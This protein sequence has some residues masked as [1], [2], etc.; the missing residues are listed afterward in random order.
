MIRGHM[1][2]AVGRRRGDEREPHPLPLCVCPFSR[3]SRVRLLSSP[4]TVAHQ[5]SL[6]MQFS[7]Q[8]CWSG[9]PFP[10]PGDLPDPGIEPMSPASPSLQANSLP[11]SHRGSPQYFQM[12]PIFH[13]FHFLRFCRK[14]PFTPVLYLLL[15]GKVVEG[16]G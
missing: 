16:P 1:N 8:E 10:P 12:H 4:W 6:S 14:L 15:G 7:R 9:L 5:A 2:P 11:L 13:Q 3:F